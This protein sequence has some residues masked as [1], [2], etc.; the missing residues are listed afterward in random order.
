MDS[1]GTVKALLHSGTISFTGNLKDDKKITWR[2][3]TKFTT[4]RESI[5]LY[6]HNHQNKYPVNSEYVLYLFI[7]QCQ[8]DNLFFIF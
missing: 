3:I 2:Y 1:Q 5:I 4:N 7:S 6:V 8:G